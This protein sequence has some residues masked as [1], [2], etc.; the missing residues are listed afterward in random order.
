MANGPEEPSADMRQLA[1]AYRDM[2]VAL[3]LEGFTPPEALTI[4]G[5]VIAASLGGKS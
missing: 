4:I 1:S 3:T 2:Y 5:H